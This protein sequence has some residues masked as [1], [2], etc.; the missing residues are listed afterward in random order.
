MK[1]EFLELCAKNGLE[2]SSVAFEELER[3]HKMEKIAER[4]TLKN[5]EALYLILASNTIPT[6]DL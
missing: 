1:S 2:P 5:I 3:F 4:K 6:I